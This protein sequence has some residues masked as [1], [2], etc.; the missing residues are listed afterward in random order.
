MRVIL[1]ACFEAKWLE[2]LTQDGADKL[3]IEE[4]GVYPND[5]EDPARGLQRFINRWKNN[6]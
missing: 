5:G 4:L 2:F 3:F 1:N 6:K